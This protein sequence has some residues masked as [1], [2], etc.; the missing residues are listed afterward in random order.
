MYNC[1]RTF[2]YICGV[3]GITTFYLIINLINK[4]Y[5]MHKT[6]VCSG[7]GKVCNWYMNDD[8]ELENLLA[9]I[10]VCNSNNK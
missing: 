5:S 10:G 1:T 6:N 3:T 9:M 8:A 4:E 7:F 2:I